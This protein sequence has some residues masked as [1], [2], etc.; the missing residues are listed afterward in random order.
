MQDKTNLMLETERLII[1]ISGKKTGVMLMNT[2][3][4]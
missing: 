2:I 1:R 4:T 3:P